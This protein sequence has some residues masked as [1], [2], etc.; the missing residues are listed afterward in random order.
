MKSFIEKAIG[1]SLKHDDSDE[2]VE[3]VVDSDYEI[4]VNYPY[5]IRR[6]SNKR[7]VSECH[8]KDGYIVCRLNRHQYKKHRIVALQ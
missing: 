5:A 8:D 6:K 2:W 7:I 4:N 1:R 3:C